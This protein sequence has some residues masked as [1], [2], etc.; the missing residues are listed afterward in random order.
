MH[1]YFNISKTLILTMKNIFVCFKD[2]QTG[3][4]KLL[5]ILKEFGFTEFKSVLDRNQYFDLEKD[6]FNRP[7]NKPKPDTT[8]SSK[9]KPDTTQSGKP[10]PDSTQS[11]SVKSYSANTEEI[12]L[13]DSADEIE[14]KLFRIWKISFTTDLNAENVLKKIKNLAFVEY[15]H[16]ANTYELHSNPNDPKFGVQWY[17]PQVKANLAWNITQGNGNIVVAVVDSGVDYNHQDINTNMW[18]NPLNNKYGYNFINYTTD[19]KD[20]VGHGTHVAGVIGAVINNSINVAGVAK[21]KIMAIKAFGGPHDEDDNMISGLRWAANNGA[22]II[23]NSWGPK[24][25]DGDFTSLNLALQFVAAKNAISVFSAGN[26]NL[27]IDTLFP[28]V[29]EDKI[30]IVAAS[31]TQDKKTGISNYGEKTTIV[32]PGVTIQ[33]LAMNNGNN[34]MDGTSAA[35]PIVCGAIALLLSQSPTLTLIQI[36]DLLRASSDTLY[37]S[38]QSQGFNANTGRLNIHRLLLTNNPALINQPQNI[39]RNI[40]QI[41]LSPPLNER[42]MNPDEKKFLLFQAALINNI[43]TPLEQKLQNVGIENIPKLVERVLRNTS[44][45]VVLMNH[46]KATEKLLWLY[47]DAAAMYDAIDNPG[48]CPDGYYV[49]TV[50][51]NATC[52]QSPNQLLIAL[53][54]EEEVEV[55]PIDITDLLKNNVFLY[56]NCEISIFHTINPNLESKKVVVEE[57]FLRP[58]S[59]IKILDLNDI[60]N[61]NIDNIKTIHFGAPYDIFIDL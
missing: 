29:S 24:N 23:N 47:R 17:L 58:Q 28:G 1:S 4:S 27:N 39:S 36:K 19:P 45:E 37:Q 3:P 40:D 10:K 20:N 38:N 2:L 14:K 54:P 7:S 41:P 42:N 52:C 59:D 25:R 60:D 31:D 9:P 13:S 5:P 50:N 30:I 44:P 16:F 15:A 21:V 49:C 8:Q 56:W 32:A 57:V 48:N 43:R 22:K 51:G 35:A 55:V 12:L 11:D 26:D 53:Q 61:V 18:K 34:S 46:I 33:S 6:G